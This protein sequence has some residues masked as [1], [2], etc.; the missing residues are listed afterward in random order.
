MG[1]SFTSDCLMM[2]VADGLGGHFGGDIAAELTLRNLAQQFQTFAKPN[3]R[4]PAFFLEAGLLSSHRQ[5]LSDTIE[6]HYPESPRTTIAACV[7][8]NGQMWCA[9]AGDTRVYL[10]RNGKV[11]ARTRDHSKVET[12]VSLGLL[13]P[14][15]V[16]TH[17][18]RNKVLNCLGT[19]LEPLIEISHP[20]DLVSGD[21][22]LLCS[23]GLWGALAEN[24]WI[25]DLIASPLPHSLPSVLAKAVS[26]GGRHADNATALAIVWEQ[27][28]PL[29]VPTDISSSWLPDGAIT[30]TITM[31]ADNQSAAAKPIS[32]DEL[33]KAVEEIRN[34]IAAQDKKKS[35]GST[36]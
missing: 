23:D 29:L 8:Q 2:A 7:I 22:I 16:E 6:N 24:V 25:E 11:H 20:I 27:A 30:T 34:A 3:L 31:G 12:L 17:P 36:H 10:V 5:I 14:D 18:D 19:E 28:D 4:D 35:Q 9:H 15:Q 13:S 1:Y 33:K 26:R 21:L 32:E